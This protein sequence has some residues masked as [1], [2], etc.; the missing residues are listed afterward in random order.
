MCQKVSVCVCGLLFLPGPR[1]SAFSAENPSWLSSGLP[2][3]CSWREFSA[4][5]RAFRGSGFYSKLSA[6][7]ERHFAAR[8]LRPG[9]GLRGTGG[10]VRGRS[11]ARLPSPHCAGELMNRVVI[12]KTCQPPATSS[13]AADRSG[14]G[15]RPRSLSW[16]AA[17]KP[18]SAAASLLS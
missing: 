17:P 18:Q 16:R 13:L 11:P 1:L 14:S 8:R 15:R 7:A 2:R 10:R 4:E 6:R 5:T 9:R 3:A 12:F